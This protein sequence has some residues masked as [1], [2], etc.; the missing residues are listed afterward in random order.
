MLSKKSLFYLVRTGSLEEQD[1]QARSAADLDIQD[2]PTNQEQGVSSERDIRNEEQPSTQSLNVEQWTTERKA[3]VVLGIIKGT[4][5]VAEVS[6]RYNLTPQE[7]EE[8]VSEA[9][10][11]MEKALGSEHEETDPE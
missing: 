3:E 6:R 7:I 1:F 5:T 8:W 10:R 4:T 2:P 11:G 9:K